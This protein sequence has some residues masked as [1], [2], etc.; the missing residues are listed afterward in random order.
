MKDIALLAT[1]RRRK[2]SAAGRADSRVNVARAVRLAGQVLLLDLVDRDD[3]A[4][5]A[6]RLVAG[7]DCRSTEDLALGVALNFFCQ[8]RLRP[9]LAYASRAARAQ[10]QRWRQAEKVDP[11]LA[12]RFEDVLDRHYGCVAA[13]TA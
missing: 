9:E 1:V 10:S 4:W 2:Q 11:A 7:P 3:L 6:W 8:T 13:Q 12:S 5:L